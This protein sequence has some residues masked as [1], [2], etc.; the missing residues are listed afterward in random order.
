MI[1][2]PLPLDEDARLRALRQLDILDTDP[3][4]AFDRI[5][6]LAAFAFAMPIV[7][8]SLVDEE[9]QWFKS[10]HGLA[11][12]ETPR[13]V[14]FCA[15]AVLSKRLLVV[16][17]AL[18]DE[19]FL[20]NPLV[21]GAPNIRFYAGS[22][23]CLADG[24]V[25]GTL[26]LIDAKP[27]AF[28]D[29]Q[30]AMLAEFALL[31]ER[32]LE[33]RRQLIR[34][35]TEHERDR[36]SLAISEARFRTVFQQTPIG[37][38]VVDLDGRFLDV[39]QKFTQIIGYEESELR[40]L[41]FASV[42]H[43]ADVAADLTHV[44]ELLAGRQASYAMEKRY[45]RP[46]G[47]SVWVNLAVS[48]VRDVSGAPLHFIAAVQDISSR[49][50]SEEALRNYHVELEER[51]RERTAELRRSRDALQTITDNLPALI[52]VV[53]RNLCYQFNNQAFQRVFAAAPA[54][55][56]GRS[57]R[58][59]LRPDVF[60]QL[61]PLFAR[62]LAG[63]RVTCDD[64]RYAVDAERVW[65]ATYIPVERDGQVTG[66][67]VMSHDVT[68]QRR[69]EQRLRESA[70]V[71]PLTGLANRRALQDALTDLRSGEDPFA[72]FFIDMDGFK[73]INDRY[74]HDTGD[75]L[76]K[77]VASR[78]TATVRA[79]DVVSRLGGD[80]FV[81]ASQGVSDARTGERIA[82]AICREVSKPFEV[83]GRVVE[84]SASVGVVLAGA[85]GAAGVAGATS[86]SSAG[87]SLEAEGRA[88]ADD[89]LC[90]AD[91]AMYE[92]K[93]AGRN[94]WRVAPGADELAPVASAG[95]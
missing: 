87:L 30:A 54:T 83:A 51:V 86:A 20:D 85:T 40:K 34:S 27:R 95:A 52:A 48:L 66:F 64:V 55:L 59:T 79:G 47:T 44:A 17:D 32:E 23:L 2:A 56:R 67:Y 14:S 65:Q 22:P 60:E 80:E 61:Q 50:K 26:C 9:R 62:A 5:A 58:E 81:V 43:P 73:D 29:A 63:E 8:V 68:E 38:A 13:S 77:E 24:Q 39:N 6:R 89:P 74:G 71:D 90:L 35:R 49:K 31:V 12:C 72:L 37:K 28:D 4:E 91:A 93:R 92:A 1:T 78:L 46:D 19:R 69:T 25:V 94:T 76:L 15:H 16:E 7:L 45:L 82:A 75:A 33:L 36:R 84:T 21:T 41:T 42:T 10:H 11:A 57:L 18:D 70:L 53:D 3:E 88:L